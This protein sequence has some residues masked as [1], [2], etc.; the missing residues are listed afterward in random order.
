MMRT[1]FDQKNNNGKHNLILLQNSNWALSKYLDKNKDRF[2]KVIE[3]NHFINSRMVIDYLVV[4]YFKIKNSEISKEVFQGEGDK[5]QKFKE[6]YGDEKWKNLEAWF[7]L[8]V[9]RRYTLD[10]NDIILYNSSYPLSTEVNIVL[11]EFKFHIDVNE[12]TKT[13]VINKIESILQKNIV[14][15]L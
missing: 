7:V 2:N 13:F 10:E 11:K 14:N 8:D 4:Q 5:I 9:L 12:K 6:S 15:N 1:R 3:I